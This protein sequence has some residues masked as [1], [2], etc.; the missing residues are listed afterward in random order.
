VPPVPATPVVPPVAVLPAVPPVPATLP[1]DPAGPAPP[2]DP[3]LLPPPVPARTLP[4]VPPPPRPAIP[5]PPMPAVPT[6]ASAGTSPSASPAWLTEQPIQIP[7]DARQATRR[8]DRI[9]PT[10]TLARQPD[11]RRLWSISS[12]SGIF[13]SSGFAATRRGGGIQVVCADLSRSSSGRPRRCGRSWTGAVPSERAENI[14]AVIRAPVQ[15]CVGEE[16]AQPMATFPRENKAIRAL[17]VGWR[18]AETDESS[19]AE[20]VR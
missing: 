17:T 13:C 4:A 5:P 10:V 3:P 20:V 15:L 6:P 18:A 12:R 14:R 9:A 2:L 8:R 19:A 16:K 7:N 11:D 1:P